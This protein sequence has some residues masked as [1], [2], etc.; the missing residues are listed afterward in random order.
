MVAVLNPANHPNPANPDRSYA[1][2]RIYTRHSRESGNPVAEIVNIVLI[3]FTIKLL[4]SGFRRN[5]EL[6]ISSA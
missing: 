1:V 4:D 3:G 5:D 2:E 6:V